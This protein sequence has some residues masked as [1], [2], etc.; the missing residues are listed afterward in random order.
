[1]K[2]SH[3]IVGLNVGGAELMLRRLIASHQKMAEYQHEVI[4]LTDIGKIGQDLQCQGITVHA[5]GMRNPLDIFFTFVRLRKLLAVSRPDIVQTWM[6]HADFLGGLAA[7]SLGIR[8]IIWGIRTTEIRAGGS[9]I[10]RVIRKLCAL[11]SSSV[12]SKIVCAANAARRV[13]EGVGYAPDKMLVIPNGFCMD[14]LVASPEQVE[15]I[16][17]QAGL[18]AG[19]RLVGS[20]GRFNVVK[21]QKNFVQAAGLLLSRHRN[22]RFLMVGRDLDKN[23]TQLIQWI[24]ETG[25]PESFILLGERSDVPACLAAMDIFCLHSR[26]EGFPNVVGE[27]MAMGKP[28]VVTDVGDAAYLVADAGL[29]VPK[30]N[31]EALAAGIERLLSLSFGEL[32]DLGRC[33][34]QRIHAQFTMEHA[35]KQFEQVY[36]ELLKTT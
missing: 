35:R 10:T 29:V 21:D 25:S 13:H 22:L 31:P 15:I 27:A 6:Y 11:L 8:R 17:Q 24:S 28:C 7:R 12:P 34:K 33:A 14:A 16:R 19:L 18:T 3:I 1:M 20:V 5:L 30:E 23:N 36:Q 9:R 32:S 26:T 2:V 4:S